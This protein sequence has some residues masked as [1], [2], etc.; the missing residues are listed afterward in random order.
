MERRLGVT[1]VRS[2]LGEIVDKVQ[3]QGDTVVLEKNGKP[4]A[5]L[6]SFALFEQFLR[7]RDAAYQV[8]VDVQQQNQDLKMNEDE[9]LTFVDEAV[10][11]VRKQA[12]QP[13]KTR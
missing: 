9:L 6:I 8:V 5:V 10:H 13:A 11:A 12:K 2:R 3:Y 4:A 7:Q 1:E